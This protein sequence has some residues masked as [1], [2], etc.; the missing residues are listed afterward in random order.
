MSFAAG[1]V[2]FVRA[3]LIAR[4]N[5]PDAGAALVGH[6]VSCRSVGKTRKCAVSLAKGEE[7]TA[8]ARD[9][10][11]L[12]GRRYPR[13]LGSIRFRLKRHVRCGLGNLSRIR[14]ASLKRLPN[15]KRC[16]KSRVT[17]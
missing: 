10:R 8:D 17:E 2:R 13:G 16:L 11:Y 7:Q 14:S 9:R 4:G 5:A 3:R 1:G 15:E 12:E 6:P